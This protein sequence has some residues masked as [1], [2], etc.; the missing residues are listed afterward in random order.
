MHFRTANT[1]DSHGEVWGCENWVR[2]TRYCAHPARLKFVAK[3]EAQ[4][5]GSETLGSLPGRRWWNALVLPWLACASRFRAA[6]EHGVTSSTG[7]TVRA[8]KRGA[9]EISTEHPT[10]SP[11]FRFL[12]FRPTSF[13]TVY[14]CLTLLAV[15]LLLRTKRRAAAG[16]VIALFVLHCSNDHV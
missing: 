13:D 8:T 15:S 4:A 1:Y 2:L 12:C 14:V 5:S 7:D 16:S 9:V 3:C 6:N 11:L 10:L